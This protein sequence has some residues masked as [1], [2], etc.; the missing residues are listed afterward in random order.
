M[1]KVSIIDDER[2]NNYIIIANDFLLDE[3]YKSAFKAYSRAL[4]FA[5]TSVE[6]IDVYYEI[7]DIH[8]IFDQYENAIE[9]YNEIIKLDEESSGAYYGIAVSHELLGSDLRFAEKYYKLAIKYDENYDRAYYY[10]GHIYDRLGDKEKALELFR[11]CVEIDETDFVSINDI[12]SIYE[13][14]GQFDKAK[15]YFERSLKINPEYSMALYNMGVVYKRLGDVDTAINYY[16]KSLEEE[17]YHLTYLN[18]SAIYIERNQLDKTLEILDE[19]IFYNPDSVNLHY[20]R[21]CTFSKLG[22]SKSAYRDIKRAIEIN[23][24]AYDWAFSDPDLEELM[25]REYGSNKNA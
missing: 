7:A 10:L 17:K 1:I 19:G 11:K 25:R 5:K 13:E 2:Y 24:D 16:Y 9:I 4:N 20:N 12:G 21:A 6:K 18:L 15:E 3:D 8:L 14:F 22:D 23:S